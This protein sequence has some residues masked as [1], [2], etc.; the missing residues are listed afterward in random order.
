MRLQLPDNAREAFQFLAL[1]VGV[2]LV[3]R[4]V[5]AGIGTMAPDAGDD[6][7]AQA[8]APYRNGYPLLGA[9]CSAVGGGPVILRLAAGVL[10]ALCCG[11]AGTLV[12]LPMGTRRS[13]LPRA[14]FGARIGLLGG[15]AWA[16]Y[17]VLCLPPRH[18][19]IA[20]TTGI[21]TVEAP[22]FLGMIAWPMA[23]NEEL[24]PWAE[25]EQVRKD[26]QDGGTSCGGLT[27][28][29]AVKN[30]RLLQLAAPVPTDDAC[31]VQR[32]QQQRD[33]ERLVHAVAH[34]L[35]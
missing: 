9:H 30:D 20:P 3:V 35:E 13:T 18:T 6:V 33:A 31:D 10:F 28:V 32:A 19:T 2:V 4:L 24:H 29:V 23:S 22:A 21:T 15:S 17:C 12:L 14:V 8:C 11:L 5:V 26:L 7:L 34:Y 1:G 16:L 25:L 27:I